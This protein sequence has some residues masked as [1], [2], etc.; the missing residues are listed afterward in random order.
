MLHQI[1]KMMSVV[2]SVFTARGGAEHAEERRKILVGTFGEEH[3]NIPKGE[4]IIFVVRILFFAGFWSIRLII[5]SNILVLT[6]FFF[7]LSIA[8]S[9]GLFL[10]EAHFDQYN[11]QW[12]KGEG[13]EP[14]ELSAELQERAE[15]FARERIWPRIADAVPEFESFHQKDLET[16]ALPL[17]QLV[18]T[19]EKIEAARRAKAEA[20]KD[21]HGEPKMRIE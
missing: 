14:V 6:L 15:Q 16:Y 21:V 17:Q 4:K 10:R 11:K 3:V 13:R 12:G 8:P 1:R 18:E 2:F 7:L 5:N 20:K 9:A 19:G